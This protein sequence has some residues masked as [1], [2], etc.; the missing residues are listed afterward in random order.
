MKKE[1]L[2][3]LDFIRAIAVVSI[4]ITHFNARY[5][6]TTPQ[7]LEKMI[8]TGSVS[9][10][11]IGNWGVSLFFIISGA[12]LMYVYGEKLNLANFF[13]KRALSIYPMFWIAY[14]IAFLYLF[15][16]N[17]GAVS[18][19]PKINIILSIIG[20]DGY[21]V[22]NMPTFYIL[23]EWFLG[24]IIL[25]YILFPLLRKLVNEYPILL[26]CIVTIIYIYIIFFYNIP[27]NKSKFIFTRIPEIL[28]GMYFIKYIKR[29]PHS[30][31]I[32][33]FMVL[34]AN[35]VFKP[36]WDVSLQ[37]TYVGIAS[38][39]VLVYISKYF[40]IKC[41][42]KICGTLGKYSYSIFLVHHIVIA[43]M[44]A[45][46]DLVAISRAGS[47]VLF[48]ACVGVIGLLSFLLYKL[49]DVVISYIIECFT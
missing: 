7:F 46:F 36:T 29:V 40:N 12:S 34:V 37:T 13:K 22:E 17:K 21:M 16:I 32:I 35:W 48:L 28:L 14:T 20:F 33:S 15:Y 25:M 5:L 8:I 27:F 6:Y 3:Y 1:R 26:M 30:W 9:N 24:A 45:T 23:G 43:R 31:A 2:F 47:Y 10:I 19:A 41:V 4:V 18:G 44:M 49:N 39:F 11:Y 38:F 42:Q